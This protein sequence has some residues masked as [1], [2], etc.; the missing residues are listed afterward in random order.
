MTIVAHTR[1][2][3]IGADTHARTHT[4]AIL[5]APTGEVIASE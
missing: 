4:I 5:A 3:V 1:P 2:F